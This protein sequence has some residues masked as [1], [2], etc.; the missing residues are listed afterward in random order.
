M[1]EVMVYLVLLGLAAWYL[2]RFLKPE[3]PWGWTKNVPKMKR[4]HPG[5]TWVQVYETASA[6]EAQQIQARLQEE[7]MECIVYQQGK[8]DIHGN[9]LKGTGIAVPKASVTRA[10]KIISRLPV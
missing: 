9:L 4:A 8:K 2:F 3:Y 7:G 5:E 6:D 1:A 10:Q